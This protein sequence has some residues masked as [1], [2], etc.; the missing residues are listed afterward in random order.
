[1]NVTLLLS[2]T[3]QGTARMDGYLLR[4]AIIYEREG[5]FYA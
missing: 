5:G 2:A 1:M 4:F 3:Q